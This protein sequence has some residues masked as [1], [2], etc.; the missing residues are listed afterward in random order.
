MRGG[1]CE[2]GGQ[3]QYIWSPLKVPLTQAIINY[4]CVQA[5][6]AFGRACFAAR[7]ELLRC[8]SLWTVL[9]SV[10]PSFRSV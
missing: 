9:G 4:I 10:L 2:G 8:V 1:E 6:A 3:S 5:N 7:A